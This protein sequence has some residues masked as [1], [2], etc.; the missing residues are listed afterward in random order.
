MTKRKH[1]RIHRVKNLAPTQFVK[2][3]TVEL[4]PE[5]LASYIRSA[6][7]QAIPIIKEMQLSPAPAQFVLAQYTQVLATGNSQLS[8]ESAM[9]ISNQ[10]L[11]LWQEGI[12]QPGPDYPYTLEETLRDFQEEHKRKQDYASCF[13]PLTPTRESRGTGRAKVPGGI[14]HHPE[15]HLWQAWM[16][17][18]GPCDYFG[19]YHDPALAQA[20]LETIISAV[21]R[22]ATPSEIETLYK[23]VTSQGDGSV[24]QIPF[25]MMEYLLDHLDEYMIAL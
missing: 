19:A 8:V 25:E 22:K 23:R 18:D 3:R 24:K 15:T 16:I 4:K 20:A 1:K 9:S 14:V 12:Y 7:Q 2:T 11:A 13:Q 10:V 5:E 6:E 17:I 21:R